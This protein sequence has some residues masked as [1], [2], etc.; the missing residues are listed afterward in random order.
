M[1]VSP[2]PRVSRVVRKVLQLFYSAAP[3]RPALSRTLEAQLGPGELALD[4]AQRTSVFALVTCSNVTSDIE[5]YG[6]QF[7]ETSGHPSAGI[8]LPQVLEVSSCPVA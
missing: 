6:P 5:G 7:W 1:L 2:P 4:S 3:A 8:S